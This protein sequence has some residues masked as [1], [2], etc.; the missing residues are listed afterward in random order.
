MLVTY[1]SATYAMFYIKTHSIVTHS[2]NG[3]T[4]FL[5]LSSVFQHSIVHWNFIDTTQNCI[6]PS[7]EIVFFF[8]IFDE[9]IMFNNFKSNVDWSMIQAML[10]LNINTFWQLFKCDPFY[11][12]LQFNYTYNLRQQKKE[13]RN[14]T[15]IHRRLI[16]AYRWWKCGISSWNT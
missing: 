8:I 9:V 14:T 12:L 7:Y 10:M 15:I 13:K 2:I 4:V 11:Q 3:S 5:S 16:S 1:I 6:F